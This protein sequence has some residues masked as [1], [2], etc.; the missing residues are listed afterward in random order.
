MLALGT[1]LSLCVLPAHRLDAQRI[2]GR[3]KLSGVVL[4]DSL[5]RPIAGAELILHSVGLSARSDSAGGFAFNDLPTGRHRLTARAVGYQSVS[6]EL[7]IP[8]AGLENLDLLLRPVTTELE[9][10]DVRAKAAPRYLVDFE[11]RRKMGIGRF[12]DSTTLWIHGDPSQWAQRLVERIPGL[13][14]MGYGG[15]KALAT[16]R[17]I[18]TLRGL[19]TGDGS[20]V[21]RGA[22]PACYAR[23]IVDGVI[24]YNSQNGE[25]LFDVANWSGPPFVAAEF[26][27]SSQVPAEFNRL[28]SASCGALVLWTR[29]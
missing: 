28:G 25:G 26:Y 11:S 6:M 23:V 19:P 16:T 4:V 7:D 1:A 2:I 29:R 22:R 17:G 13:R 12:M 24:Q 3:A 20:D 21:M 9:R 27:T 15:S 10:V 8:S 5:E 14:A 18:G